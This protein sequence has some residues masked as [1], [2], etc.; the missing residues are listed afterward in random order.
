[1]GKLFD[2]DAMAS[3]MYRVGMANRRLHE[4]SNSCVQNT[5]SHVQEVTG[6]QC[7]HL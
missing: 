4:S 2:Q 1:M 3:T 6:T 7:L 5:G